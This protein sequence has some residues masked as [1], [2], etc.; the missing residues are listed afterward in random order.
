MTLTKYNVTMTFVFFPSV[1]TS[2]LSL[3][4]DTVTFLP[5]FSTETMVPSSCLLKENDT[6]K[7]LKDDGKKQGKN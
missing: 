4:I 2:R 5:D 1:E 6:M 3:G 7:I